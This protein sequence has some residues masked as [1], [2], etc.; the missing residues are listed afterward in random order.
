MQQ[1]TNFARGL[2]FYKL[3]WI[4]T[5]GCVAGVV[6]ENI[7][8]L[9][10]FHRITNRVGLV[11]GPFNPIYGMGALVIT[12][13][14]VTNTGCG[15]FSA[16][17]SLAAPSSTYAAGCR[18]QCLAPSPGITAICR[19]TSTDGSIWSSPYFGG[20]SPFCGHV[21]SILGCPTSLSAFP[22]ALESF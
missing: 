4:F 17:S 22:T 16:A 2:S 13:G 10:A 20:L 12:V 21:F 18:R 8:Y 11:Y 5:I 3:F 14:F 7:W 15:F 6:L 19:S 9:L 1:K